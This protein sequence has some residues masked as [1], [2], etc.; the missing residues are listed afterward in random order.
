MH[1]DTQLHG[2]AL[3]PLNL[4]WFRIATDNLLLLLLSTPLLLLLLPLLL[5][6]LQRPP[7]RR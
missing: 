5:L 3:V 7:A 4:P 1:L 2:L 6:L